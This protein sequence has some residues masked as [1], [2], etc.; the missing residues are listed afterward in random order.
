MSYDPNQTSLLLEQYLD[1]NLSAEEANRIRALLEADPALRE[2][3]EA[4]QLAIEAV[5]HKGLYTR[6]KAIR[7]DMLQ[8]APA[9]KKPARRFSYVRISM[10]IAASLLL[11]AAG[12]AIYKYVA[13]TNTSVYNDLYLQYELSRTRS[14]KVDPVETL[15]QQ[16]NWN[17]LKTFAEK[18]PGSNKNQ[19]LAGIGSLESGNAPDAIKR[20]EFI[21]NQNA[22]TGSDLFRDEAEYYLALAYI[23]NG[24]PLKASVQLKMIRR[25]PE[26]P[27][28][29]K[30][31]NAS[32]IDMNILKWKD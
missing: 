4:L 12:F 23:R 10:Q 15:Y 22:Q 18:N 32:A 14:T 13:V 27:Y 8:N 26:H 21:L 2:E 30:A 11:F 3:L 24:E 7:E 9:S 16:K 6:V 1:G 28:R 5:K 29:E 20:F 31:A 19:F 17:E 25:D